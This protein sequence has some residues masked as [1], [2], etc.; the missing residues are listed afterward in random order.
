MLLAFET[1]TN[2]CSVAFKDDGGQIHEKRIEKRGAHSEQLFLF[3]EEL[4]KEQGF[5]V[6][7]L[8]AVLVSEGPGSYTGL[9]ISAS[10]VKGLL[11]GTEIPLY[12]I[13]TLAGFAQSVFDQG[14][15][16]ETIHSV[17]DARRVHLYHQAFAV[18]E[19]GLQAETEVEIK[20]IEQ[21]QEMIKPGDTVVGT[22]TKR[23]DE[24]VLKNASVFGPEQITARAL[25]T[26]YNN[27]GQG[28]PFITRADPESYDPKYYTSRQAKK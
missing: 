16:S 20:P 22:G 11:F 12:A 14:I 1:A 27:S 21:V 7:D 28:S 26:L 23:I 17:I 5:A 3:L 25:I 15:K 6:S 24:E 19:D 9:R 2:V 10:A 13:N 4:M 18:E 8:K